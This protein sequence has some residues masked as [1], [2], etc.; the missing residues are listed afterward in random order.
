M[1][2]LIML[3]NSGIQGERNPGVCNRFCHIC[4]L[5][6]LSH[7]LP[8]SFQLYGRIAMFFLWFSTARNTYE[9]CDISQGRREE[10]YFWISSRGVKADHKGSILS[11]TIPHWQCILRE[12]RSRDKW[13]QLPRVDCGPRNENHHLVLHVN[14]H[15]KGMCLPMS[16]S[17]L[18]MPPTL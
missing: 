9:C 13:S 3:E 4:S 6:L 8:W 10:N 12:R 18:W 14:W 16:Q 17:L 11:G 5:G 2:L 7:L 15:A 1:R